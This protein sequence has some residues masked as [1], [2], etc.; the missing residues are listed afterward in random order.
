MRMNR[1]TWAAV[2][3]AG[4]ILI[5]ASACAKPDDRPAAHTVDPIAGADV[6]GE[7]P[8]APKKAQSRKIADCQQNSPS[9]RISRVGYDWRFR[10]GKAHVAVN[11]YT[12]EASTCTVFD[13]SGPPDPQVPPD[14]LL[15]SFAGTGGEGVQ[16]EFSSVDFSGGTAPVNGKKVDPA[17]LT[18]PIPARVGVSR[19]GE[20]LRADDCSLSITKASSHGVAGT[21]TCPAAA[22]QKANPF[23][24]TDDV[25]YDADDELQEQATASLSGWFEVK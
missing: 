4:L 17:P 3:A 16:I 1:S 23:D 10:A 8:E 18:G 21:F 9:G 22:P 7:V 5:G 2:A 15:F 14:T 19:D 6:A 25:D 20:Y 24:P 13:R 12:N 11:P